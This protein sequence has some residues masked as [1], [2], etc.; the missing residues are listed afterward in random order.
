M[1]QNETGSDKNEIR[2]RCRKVEGAGVEMCRRRD[3]GRGGH[4]GHELA[5]STGPR[6][7]AGVPL[8]R[9]SAVERPEQV[10]GPTA[11]SADSE[12]VRRVERPV[13]RRQRRQLQ[14]QLYQT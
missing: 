10:R 11:M 6:V 8:P 3:D 13:S 14:S 4:D 5:G 1:S 12:R 9:Q 7:G 2:L